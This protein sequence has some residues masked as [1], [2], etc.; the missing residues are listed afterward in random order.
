VY[1]LPLLVQLE[2]FPHI[3]DKTGFRAD[4]KEKNKQHNWKT[5]IILVF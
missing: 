4:E 5:G 3:P 2:W 1:Q